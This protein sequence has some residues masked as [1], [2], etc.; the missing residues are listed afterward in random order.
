MKRFITILTLALFALLLPAHAGKKEVKDSLLRIYV[1]S[2]PD[3]TRL[4]VLHHLSL[5]DRQSPVYLY[6]QDKL[7]KEATAQK[8]LQYQSLAI[9]HHILYYYN[10]L[11]EKHTAQWVHRLERLAE[12]NNYYAD[13]CKGKKMLIDLLTINGKI[14]LAVNE[15]LDMH[16]Q[17]QRLNDRNGMREA[18]LCLLT[19]YFETMRYDEGLEALDKAFRLTLPDDP[20]IDRIALYSKAVLAYSTVYKNKELFLNLQQMEEATYE[21]LKQNDAL[22]P[23]AYPE[24]FL[25]INSHY[26]LYYIRQQQPDKARK[27]LLKAQAYEESSSFTPY[28]AIYIA[29]KAEYYRSVREYDKAIENWN[30]AIE[31]TEPFSAKDAMTYC[32]QKADL[33]VEMGCPDQ[34]LPLYKK[35]IKTK[36]SLYNDLA[37]SQMEEIQSLYNIDKLILQKEQRRTMYHYICLLISVIAL[38]A[39]IIFNIHIYRSRKRL[40]SDEKEMRKLAAIAEE[41][42]EVKSR[43]LANM[44]YNIRIPLNN[45][46]GFSQLM[47]NDKDL[48]DEEKKEY[49]AIIQKNSNELIRLVNDVL[50]LSRLE[51]N[52][53]KFQLQDCNVQEWCND[54]GYM[55]QMREEDISLQL[56]AETGDAVIHTDVNRLTQIVSNLLL[57]P[58]E[59]A[60]KWEVRMEVVYK[61]EARLISCRIENSP[62][63]D[64]RFASQKTTIRQEIT[65][66][67][68]KHFGGTFGMVKTEGEVPV[69]FFTYPTLTP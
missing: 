38:V 69:A 51:A 37:T 62:L 23:N 52:M 64:V 35:V 5:L 68:F 53:M 20:P 8:R 15:A 30:K 46:V 29:T 18:Y 47:T 9:Y 55:V 58:E 12:E 13:Y 2:P 67:F 21:F 60:G 34:A 49:S 65:R 28:N 19:G 39:L 22:L 16:K 36:D 10:R 32:I 40:K 24:F 6:Y 17:A 56:H 54:L 14:E 42:N 44:S 31:L 26:A 3:T 66:L 4:E 41:A 63:A 59:S 7:L 43:F 11:D 25:F 45:V 48:S 61:P 1:A 33:L 27:Y 57:P 50:D